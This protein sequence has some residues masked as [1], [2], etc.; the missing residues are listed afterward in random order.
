MLGRP[1]ENRIEIA[2]NEIDSVEKTN[3][4]TIMGKT[5]ISVGTR[6]RGTFVFTA[7]KKKRDDA[8]NLLLKLSEG[9]K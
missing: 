5:E 1:T 9:N 7:P 2:V 8:V 3:T 4:F 6:S